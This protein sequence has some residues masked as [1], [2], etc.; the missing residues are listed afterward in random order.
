VK[1]RWGLSKKKPS[2]HSL[3]KWYKRKTAKTFKANLS[4][5]PKR[6]VMQD[7]KDPRA[8]TIVERYE[9]EG[10]QK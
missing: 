7:H 5:S 9:N 6:F 2:L 1:G 4:L 10:S 8:F 3:Y